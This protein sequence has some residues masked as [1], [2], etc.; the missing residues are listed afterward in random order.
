MYRIL[1]VIIF[2]LGISYVF[3]YIRANGRMQWLYKFYTNNGK[4]LFE[5]C[6][7]VKGKLEEKEYIT[8]VYL[9]LAFTIPLKFYAFRDRLICI[10]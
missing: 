1:Y 9:I 7:G 4:F 3:E 5:V 8:R 6:K 10:S 2:I